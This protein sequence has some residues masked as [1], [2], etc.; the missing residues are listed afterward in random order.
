MRNDKR[1]VL[2]FTKVIIKLAKVFADSAVLWTYQRAKFKIYIPIYQL[3]ISLL[4]TDD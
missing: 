2:F 1:Y 4:L 3:T